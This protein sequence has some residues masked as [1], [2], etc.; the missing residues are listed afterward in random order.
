MVD[1]KKKEVYWPPYKQQY[2]YDQALI[3]A[4]TPNE[5]QWKLHTVAR[6]FF[7]CD[8]LHKAYQKLRQCQYSSDVQSEVEETKTEKRKRIP[9]KR[10]ISSEDESSEASSSKLPR[11]PR[12]DSPINT[13]K[14]DGPRNKIS[15][16]S[17]PGIQGINNTNLEHTSCIT[18]L[19]DA[20]RNTSV[21]TTSTPRLDQADFEHI[22]ED[23]SGLNTPVNTHTSRLSRTGF[24]KNSYLY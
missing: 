21:T 7:D 17:T 11:P 10:M 20:A 3:K 2:K 12:F 23:I 18:I 16:P 24:E 8:D 22:S 6:C 15:E 9:V 19:S 14:G 4:E 5:Q 13:F 1:A